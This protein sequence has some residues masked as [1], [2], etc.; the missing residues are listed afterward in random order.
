MGT[1]KESIQHEVCLFEPKSLEHTF[2]VARKV[3]SKNMATR[4]VVTNNYREKHAPSPNP[5]QPTRL[6]PQKKWMKEEKRDFVLI[7]KE[8]IVRGIIVVRRNYSI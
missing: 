1:L 2:I 8:S 5:T 3:E 4:R 7:V 6:T